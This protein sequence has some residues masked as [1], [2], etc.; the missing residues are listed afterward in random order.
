M[1]LKPGKADNMRRDDY[2]GQEVGRDFKEEVA[3]ELG[4]ADH[5]GVGA[6]CPVMVH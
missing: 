2:A 3:F 1:G 6:P 4:F 5:I